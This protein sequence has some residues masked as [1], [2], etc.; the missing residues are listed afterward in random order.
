MFNEYIIIF[1]VYDFEK[2]GVDFELK[3]IGFVWDL[4]D[5]I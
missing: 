5:Y 4:V 1:G 2:L 3:L